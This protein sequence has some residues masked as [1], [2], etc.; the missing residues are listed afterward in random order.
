[1]CS[2][3][4]SCFTN[5]DLPHPHINWL[6]LSPP[7]DRCGMQACCW[8]W[9]RSWKW[10]KLWRWRISPYQYRLHQNPE[11]QLGLRR[12]VSTS[13]SNNFPAPTA[14]MSVCFLWE[15]GHYEKIM[16][17]VIKTPFFQEKGTQFAICCIDH[18]LA[19]CPELSVR[20]QSEYSSSLWDSLLQTNSWN[21]SDV[22]A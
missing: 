20:Q 8:R 15:M 7:K 14:A 16:S 3:S 6:T 17:N 13:S 12:G 21:W 18:H 2:A 22:P 10:E 1:M 11:S 9:P 19:T 4:P 5:P